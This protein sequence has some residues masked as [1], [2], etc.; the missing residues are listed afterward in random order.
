[1]DS[2]DFIFYWVYFVEVGFRIVVRRWYVPGMEWE[3]PFKV[4]LVLFGM[5]TAGLLY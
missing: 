5:C 2:I 3:K 1:M 4:D